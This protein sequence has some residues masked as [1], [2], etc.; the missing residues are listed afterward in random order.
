MWSL[1][2]ILCLCIQGTET[3][4]DARVS[5]QQQQKSQS[6][7]PVKEASQYQPPP[8]ASREAG[9]LAFCHFR[10]CQFQKRQAS[11]AEIDVLV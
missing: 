4:C 3:W 5:I 6:T 9:S 2:N 8:E 10:F 11:G 1:R 7:R